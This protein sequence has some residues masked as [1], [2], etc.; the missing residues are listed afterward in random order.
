MTTIKDK[1]L[2][3]GLNFDKVDGVTNEK[4]KVNEKVIMVLTNKDGK[5]KKFEGTA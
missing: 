3:A 5:K 4:V 2:D 1:L